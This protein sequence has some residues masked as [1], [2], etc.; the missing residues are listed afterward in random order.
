LFTTSPQPPPQRLCPKSTWHSTLSFNA[1]RPFTT[2]CVLPEIVRTPNTTGSRPATTASPRYVRAEWFPHPSATPSDNVTTTAILFP[3]SFPFTTAITFPMRVVLP[4]AAASPNVCA[5]STRPPRSASFFVTKSSSAVNFPKSSPANAA[6]NSSTVFGSGNLTTANPI[7][8]HHATGPATIH[9]ATNNHNIVP[10]M[11]AHHDPASQPTATQIPWRSPDGHEWPAHT[12][13]APANP[14]G[15]VAC[16]HGLSGSGSEFTPVAA[17]C[18]THA[19]QAINLRGQG[20][21]PIPSRRGLR[22][23]TAAQLLHIHH[24]LDALA[25]RHP[26]LPIF[27]LGESMGALLSA[28]Y[29]A[30]PNPH[31]AVHGLILSVPVVTLRTWVPRPLRHAMHHLARLFPRWRLPQDLFVKNRAAMPPITRDQA[32]AHHLRTRPHHIKNYTLRFLLELADLIDAT[33]HH[34]TRLH[35]PTLVLA[36]GRDCFVQ[37]DHIASWFQKI[38]A[39]DKTLHTYPEA[40]H[41]LWHDWDSKKVLNDLHNWLTSHP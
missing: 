21:D 30:Q 2:D 1:A 13:P 38:P 17:R 11:T 12:W 32:Y 35:S 16:I 41:L 10:F 26:G 14:L 24:F 23:D 5:K 33:H 9:A 7:S 28:A 18:N 8:P 22:L 31:P 6:S 40:Y 3:R 15:L 19:V 20:C 29:M 37:P 4:S 36:A 39:P 34:A 25:T 27:L